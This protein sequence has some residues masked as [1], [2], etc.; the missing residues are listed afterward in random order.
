MVRAFKEPNVV[1]V[2]GEVN[3]IR[4]MEIIS[5]EL[6]QKDLQTVRKKLDE[7]NK[8]V[9]RF[10]EDEAKKE[11]VYLEKALEI[12]EGG[13]WLTKE[14]W[15]NKEITYLNNYRFFTTKPVVYLVNISAKN[16]I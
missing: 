11:I 6:V 4:D 1:H 15:T 12:L 5:N 10:N 2:E 13:N 9:E 7:L 8:K 16:F 14:E 3:P